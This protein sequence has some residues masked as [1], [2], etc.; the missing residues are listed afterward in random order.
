MSVTFRLSSSLDESRRI[1]CRVLFS[2][3][4][5]PVHVQVQAGG[6]QPGAEYA[7]LGQEPGVV[8]LHLAW[9]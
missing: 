6:Y 5:D 2:E 4:G 8:A 1:E 9:E 7:L 3:K